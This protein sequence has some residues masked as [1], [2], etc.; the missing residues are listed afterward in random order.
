MMPEAMSA[1]MGDAVNEREN[2]FKFSLGYWKKLFPV[3][4]YPKV[5]VCSRNDQPA[6]LP[7]SPDAEIIIAVGCSNQN[8]S[9]SVPTIEDDKILA[10]LH[11][12]EARVILCLSGDPQAKKAGTFNGCRFMRHGNGYT[13]WQRQ[14]RTKDSQFLITDCDGGKPYHEMST[15]GFMPNLFACVVVYVR[16]DMGGLENEK[17]RIDFHRSL[18]GQGHLACECNHYPLLSTGRKVGDRRHCMQTDCVKKETYV[19]ANRDCH[20]RVCKKCLESFPIT[21]ITYLAPPTQA[22]ED[23][24]VWMDE[25]DIVN[26]EDD[27]PLQETMRKRKNHTVEH[28]DTSNTEEDYAHPHDGQDDFYTADYLTRG[29]T[30]KEE[31]VLTG[32]YA[33]DDDIRHEG[34]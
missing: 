27:I 22:E 28:S 7:I 1:Y 18:G 23:V 3:N 5:F 9:P 31:E 24:E 33:D 8:E 11:Y 2:F 29:N 20:T 17:K 34:K 26:E 13:N 25:N 21:S 4:K 6:Y 12:F 14:L 16:I 15:Y 10:G 32:K 30:T 19:C